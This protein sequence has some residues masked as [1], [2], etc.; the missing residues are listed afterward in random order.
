MAP[1]LEAGIRPQ[2]SVPG[3][4][5]TDWGSQNSRVVGWSVWKIR[6]APLPLCDSSLPTWLGTDRWELGVKGPGLVPGVAEQ[7]APS[8]R[9][10]WGPVR[11]TG[12]SPRGCPGTNRESHREEAS[13]EPLAQGRAPW[14]LGSGSLC[15]L[16][17]PPGRARLARAAG[18]KGG[19]APWQVL[20]LSD[21]PAT[22]VI[23]EHP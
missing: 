18:Q 20:P 22:E 10:G 6:T 3:V 4:C 11:W 8:L 13:Q 23:S 12:V 16:L 17:V 9:A 19:S 21:A 1:D 15:L 14:G 5:L 7:K 2:C